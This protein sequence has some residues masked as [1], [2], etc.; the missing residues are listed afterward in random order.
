VDLFARTAEG[1]A[2]R[3]SLGE[4]IGLTWTD[5]GAV[6]SDVAVAAL[7]A[8][9]YRL[10]ARLPNGQLGIKDYADGLW[11][12]SATDW[13]SLGAPASG[14]LGQP[15]VAT[16][17]LANGSEQLDVAVFGTDHAVY[18]KSWNQDHWEPSPSGFTALS[19]APDPWADLEPFWKAAQMRG[20]PLLLTDYGDRIPRAQLLSKGSLVSLT[21]AAEIRT[22]QVDTDFTFDRQSKTITLPSQSTVPHATLAELTTLRAAG[23]GHQ[24]HDRQVA[25]TYQRMESLDP[26][27]VAISGSENLAR[28][29]DK[30]LLGKPVR[31]VVYGDSISEGYNSSGVM[32]AP[33]Y[34]PPWPVQLARRL[35][36]QYHSSVTLLNPSIAGTSSQWGK[37]HLAGRR[38]IRFAACRHAFRHARGPVVPYLA[39]AAE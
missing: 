7:R 28:L 15:A 32:G 35:T 24:F 6:S 22:Y 33:P 30:L 29:R 36:A 37:D 13:T 39:P 4:A 17:A 19:S 16:R 25:A 3:A 38:P 5:L 26:A 14:I 9:Q 27:L 2:Y 18:W 21:D 34:Y 11:N 20:E 23:E 31:V 12:P 10:L 1:R 8:N